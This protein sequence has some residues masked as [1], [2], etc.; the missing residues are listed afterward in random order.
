MRII[1]KFSINVY[2][3]WK[4]RFYIAWNAFKFHEIFVSLRG[5]CHFSVSRRDIFEWSHDWSTIQFSQLTG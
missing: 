4:Q 2:P 3:T 5:K 1:S